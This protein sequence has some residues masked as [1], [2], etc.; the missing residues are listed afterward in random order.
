[1]YVYWIEKLSDNENAF[2]GKFLGVAFKQP[3]IDER[4]YLEG[5]PLNEWSE[6]RWFSTSLVQK[7]WTDDNGINLKTLNSHYLLTLPSEEE[8]EDMLKWIDELYPSRQ[9]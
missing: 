4:F 8:K 7:I 3:E 2:R 6:C 1:M 5:K 9:K